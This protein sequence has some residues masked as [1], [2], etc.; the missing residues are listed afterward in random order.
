MF[1]AVLRRRGTL[2]HAAA[3]LGILGLLLQLAVGSV[4]VPVRAAVVAPA[5]MPWLAGAICLRTGSAAPADDGSLPHK[6]PFCPI[7]L[8]LSLGGALLLPVIAALALALGA[9]LRAPPLPSAT[10]YAVHTGLGGFA[11]APPAAA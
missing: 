7:C 11:R 1:L 4:H 9:A 2:R 6:A 3:L 10:G 5:G 8:A